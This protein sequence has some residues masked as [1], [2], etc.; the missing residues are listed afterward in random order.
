MGID[1]NVFQVTPI[2]LKHILIDC[3]DLA[4]VHQTFYNANNLY[5][6]FANVAGEIILKIIKEIYL[7]AKI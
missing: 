1:R 3:V 4:E 5:D 6:L 7:Y 2:P